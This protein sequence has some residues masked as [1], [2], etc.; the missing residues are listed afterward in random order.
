MYWLIPGLGSNISFAFQDIIAYKLSAIQSFNTIAINT[1]NHLIFIIIFFIFLAI[2]RIFRKNEVKLFIDYTIDFFKNNY[3]ILSLYALLSLSANC[4]LYYAYVFGEKLDNLNPGIASTL[5]NLSLIFSVLLPY[6]VYNMKIKKIN[7]VGI[8][9]Y[10]IAV[11]F[12]SRINE[13]K[14]NVNKINKPI[15]PDS[16]SGTSFVLDE[17]LLSKQNYDNKTKIEDKNYYTW[18]SLCI[19]SAVLYGI[20]AFSAYVTV[21][22]NKQHNLWGMTI[23]LFILESFIGG[24]LYFIFLF[25]STEPVQIGIFKNYNQDVRSLLFKLKNVIYVSIAS[26]CNALGIITLYNGYKI[27]PNPG[28]VDAISNLYTTTQA[29]LNWIIF[30][31]KLQSQQLFGLVLASTSII[32]LNL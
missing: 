14:D 20:A 10:F 21:R 9:I 25:K 23:I 12:L 2:Y 3:F 6:F 1:A 27:S 8:F 31:T 18:L 24:I 32:L 13:K 4:I 15:D 19:T 7:A 26:I 17:K 28:F 11:Y 16:T 5:S 22:N 30:G 29:I